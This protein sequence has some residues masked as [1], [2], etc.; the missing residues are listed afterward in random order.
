MCKI[1]VTTAVI[2]LVVLPSAD[3]II[4]AFSSSISGPKQGHEAEPN[5]HVWHHLT[6]AV[7]PPCPRTAL[8]GDQLFSAGWTN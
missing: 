3:H 1:A 4:I 5:Q 6:V 7:I 2:A 8:T